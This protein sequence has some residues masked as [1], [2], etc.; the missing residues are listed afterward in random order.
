MRVLIISASREIVHV[1]VPP[2]GVAYLAAYLLEQGHEVMIVDL[3]LGADFRKEISDALASFQPQVIGIS[4]RNVDAATYPGNLFFYLPVRNVILYVKEVAD[5]NVPVILGGAGFSIFAEEILRDVNHDIGIFGEG[6][7][8]F[9]EVVKR[10]KNGEDPR[11][12]DKGV[13]FI[14]NNG[15]YHQTPPWRIDNLDD[16]PFPARELLEN[17]SYELYSHG[18]GERTW[19]NIQTKRGCPRNCIFCSYK[20]LEG[21]TVR[22][23][24]PKKIAEELDFI[25]NNLGIRNIFIVDSLFNLDRAHLKEMCQEIVKKRIDFKWGANYTPKGEFI[26]LLPLLKESGATHL[27]MGIESLS[28]T[29]LNS[30]QKEMVVSEA[31]RTS[32]QC[33]ELGIEQFLHVMFGGPQETLETVRSTFDLLETLKPYGGN[34][35]GEGDILINVGLRIYPHTRLQSI[36]EEEGVIPKGLNLLKPRFYFSPTISETQLFE[37]VQEYCKIHQRWIAPGL[38]LNSPP[39]LLPVIAKQFDIYAK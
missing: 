27:A 16:L 5:P 34:W 22:Y 31:V 29:V 36:A 13:C 15:E 6:E 7:H 32:E 9:A 21:R 38:G 39:D 11:K 23:R 14:D 3:V 19:G 28:S 35:Q 20:Y 24:S 25:V 12:L 17:E 4:I 30:M 8:A 18:K 37:M 1:I 33:T 2:L 10:I 26:D